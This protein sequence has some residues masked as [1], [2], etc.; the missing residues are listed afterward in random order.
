MTDDDVASAL[1][2]LQQTT[3]RLE[4]T[5]TETSS[6]IQSDIRSLNENVTRMEGSLAA[7]WEQT[8]QQERDL[9]RLSERHAQQSKAQADQ[10]KRQINEM[11]AQSGITIPESMVKV[12]AFGAGAIILLIFLVAGLLGVGLPG[13]PIE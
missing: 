10:L 3:M 13:A 1:R 9:I 6:L 2:G 4:Q 5:L 8:R 11:P 7:N 12:A